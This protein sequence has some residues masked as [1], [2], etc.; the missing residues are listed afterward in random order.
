M[1]CFLIPNAGQLEPCFNLFP[2]H[3]F[4]MQDRTTE[5]WQWD[6]TSQA[7]LNTARLGLDFKTH[8]VKVNFTNLIFVLFFFF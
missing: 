5:P 2:S 6:I 8:V 7:S 1:L 3:K 4:S